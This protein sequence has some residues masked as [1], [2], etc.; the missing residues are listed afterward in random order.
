MIEQTNFNDKALFNLILKI[1][2]DKKNLEIKT[3]N[4]RENFNKDTN[5]NIEK[6]VNKILQI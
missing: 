3:E 6:E 5:Q 2:K 1:L 4:M